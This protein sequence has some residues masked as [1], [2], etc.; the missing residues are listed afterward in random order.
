MSLRFKSLSDMNE[1]LARDRGQVDNGRKPALNDEFAIAGAEPAPVKIKTK[2]RKALLEK[3][4]PVE[5][6]VLELEPPPA[7]PAEIVQ[8]PNAV[9]RNGGPQLLRGLVLPLPPSSNA[10]WRNV[11]LPA[12]G[13][14]FPLYLP[15]L[16]VLYK[17]VRTASVPGEEAK[18]YCKIIGELAMQKGFQFF[19]E[20]D[21]KIDV[22]VCP[23]DRRE[24][25]PHNYEKVL[26]DALEQAGVYHDDKQLKDTRCRLGPVTPGGKVVISLWEINHDANAVYK[27]V[28][29]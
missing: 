24:I 5:P 28:W 1:Q 12:K 2:K 11:L 16:R 22:L 21:L 29:G 13:T 3:P 17:F 19:T 27:E 8:R 4:V 6:P 9:P 15:N 7:V 20:K 10:Y 18:A 25:D 26:F 23:R 14:K